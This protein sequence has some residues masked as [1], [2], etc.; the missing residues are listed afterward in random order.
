MTELLNVIQVCHEYKQPL[1]VVAEENFK[2]IELAR[3]II[4]SEVGVSVAI[5]VGQC[6]LYRGMRKADAAKR[7][8]ESQKLF[9][10]VQSFTDFDA[11]AG[12]AVDLLKQKRAGIYQFVNP[13]LL[14]LAKVKAFC[15]QNGAAFADGGSGKAVVASA[16]SEVAGGLADAPVAFDEIVGTFID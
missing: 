10:G 8:S 1:V 15:V 12:V 14:D 11:L 3:F 16:S 13:G 6:L 9:E 7:L 4:E 2:E 5:L